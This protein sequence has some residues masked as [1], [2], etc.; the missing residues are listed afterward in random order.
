M[1]TALVVA[2]A[3]CSLSGRA[4]RKAEKRARDDVLSATIQEQLAKSP[5]VVK[6][7]VSYCDGQVNCSGS[8]VVSLTVEPGTDLERVADFVVG[9]IWR[10]RLEPVKAIN[11]GVQSNTPD[12]RPI[13]QRYYNILHDKGE[14]EAKYGRRPVGSD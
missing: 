1:V 14:L 2:L 11:V 8:V 5:S 3:G 13:L 12:F 9:A 10:S 4:Q 6:A 7:Q